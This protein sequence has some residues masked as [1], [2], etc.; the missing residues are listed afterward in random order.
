MSTTW[1]LD[2]ICLENQF[3]STFTSFSPFEDSVLEEGEMSRSPVAAIE[4]EVSEEI[5]ER[6]DC[7]LDEED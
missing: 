7:E 2:T 6:I 3:H 5:D 4:E 1:D